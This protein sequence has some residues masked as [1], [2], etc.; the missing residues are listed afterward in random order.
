MPGVDVR[1]GWGVKLYN[2][3]VKM[4]ARWYDGD[5]GGRRSPLTNNKG[6]LCNYYSREIHFGPALVPKSCALLS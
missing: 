1:R 4:Q 3:G 2:F 5:G 6:D